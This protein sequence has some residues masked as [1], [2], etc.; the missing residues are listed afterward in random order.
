MGKEKKKNPT[1]TGNVKPAG[2]G[3]RS[4]AKEGMSNLFGDEIYN[5]TPDLA[6]G[7]IGNGSTDDLR[8]ERR[9]DWVARRFGATRE[10][11]NV[12]INYSC[13]RITSQIFDDSLKG[14]KTFD[15]ITYVRKAWGDEVEEMEITSAFDL[16]GNGNDLDRNSQDITEGGI[17]DL[18]IVNPSGPKTRVE[19]N[20]S[21]KLSIPPTR[22]IRR[23]SRE[24]R[25]HG[26]SANVHWTRNYPTE[27]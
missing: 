27:Q 1:P 7:P 11:I 24:V 20:L 5:M 14:I 18:A 25:N 3:T 19:D 12:T 8:K 17:E 9:V 16:N 10:D 2:D 15:T 13:Q 4:T 23:S 22:G 21:S 6:P 26:G